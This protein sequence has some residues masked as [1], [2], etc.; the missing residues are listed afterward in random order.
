[1]IIITVSFTSYYNFTK[2][3]INNSY[4]EIINNIYFKKTVNHFLSNLE[5]KFKKIRHQIAS[6]EKFDN[7]LNQYSIKKEEIQS[8]KYKLS[9]KIN[10]DKLNT[11]QKIYLTVDQSNNS[12]KEFIF[13]ISNKERVLLTRNNEEKGNFNEVKYV[14]SWKSI[15][16]ILT[17]I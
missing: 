8:I 15:S 14:G 7:I 17:K 11:N 16:L 1:M 9:K 6:G 10:L 2:S 13:Q 12:I 4:K 3:K 5:P